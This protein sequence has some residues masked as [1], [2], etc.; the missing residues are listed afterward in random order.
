MMLPN[1]STST[2]PDGTPT[3]SDTVRPEAVAAEPAPVMAPGENPHVDYNL[4]PLKVASLEHY[5]DQ[6]EGAERFRV[7]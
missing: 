4:H 3:L 2:L 1:T 7:S 6:P 5:I